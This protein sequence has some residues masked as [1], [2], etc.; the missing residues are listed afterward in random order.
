MHCCSL[1]ARSGPMRSGPMPAMRRRRVLVIKAPFPAPSRCRSV[2]DVPHACSH[3][4]HTFLS[5]LF[6]SIFSGAYGVALGC[7]RAGERNWMPS[8]PRRMPIDDGTSVLVLRPHAYAKVRTRSGVSS[9]V[10]SDPRLRLLA[11]LDVRRPFKRSC[12]KPSDDDRARSRRT[13]GARMRCDLI[14][15]AIAQLEVARRGAALANPPQSR[16]THT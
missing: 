9:C 6:I 11:E 13:T 7:E 15:P 1:G 2:E 16:T 4:A 12:V 10:D 14:A 5:S 8:M 3:Q